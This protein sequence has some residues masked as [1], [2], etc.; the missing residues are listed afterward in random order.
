[1]NAHD[2]SADRRREYAADPW[3][4]VAPYTRC[5]VS[6]IDLRSQN[7]DELDLR[8]YLSI[9]RK[10][11]LLIF[12]AMIAVMAIVLCL[13]VLQTPQYR[14][15]ADVL[16]QARTSEQ[17]LQQ[18]QVR[19]DAARTIVDTEIEVMRSRSVVDAV[20]KDL[21]FRP[22]VS[23]ASRGETYVV[24]ITATGTDPKRA[25]DIANAY[26]ETYVRVR[27]EGQV[28]DLLAASEQVQE[29]LQGLDAETAALDDR[30]KTIDFAIAVAPNDR[31]A[32]SARIERDQIINSQQPDRLSIAT[33]RAGYVAQLDQLRLSSGLSKTGGARIVSE[34]VAASS[35]FKP[36]PRRSV[37]IALVLGLLVGVGLAFLREYLDDSISS[38]EDLEGAVP[39]LD[40]LTVVPV[41]GDWKDRKMAKL[42]SVASPQS[43]TAE[44]YR[45]LRTSMQFVGIDHTIKVTQITSPNPGEGKSTT[46]ANLGVQLSRTGRRVVLVDCDLRRPRLHEFFDLDNDIGFTS[47]LL[48]DATVADALAPVKGERNLVV[49]PSGPVPPNPSELLSAKRTQEV[50]Q[51]LGEQADFVLVDSPP[52]LPVS[53][54]LVLSRL[55]DATML[56]IAAGTTTKRGAHRAYELLEQIDAPVIG[57]VLNSVES[58]TRYDGGYGS[59]G[60]YGYVYGSPRKLKPR[61]PWRREHQPEPEPERETITIP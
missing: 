43:A 49:V 28:D 12:A 2:G 30:V 52:V 3:C 13:T 37:A 31:E 44:A 29:Q 19:S 56:V 33:R 58:G 39:A 42:V 27:R 54:S 53:D 23:I 4:A 7:A 41:V 20:E 47:I 16:L 24:S 14:S 6:R 45:T 21:G 8:D 61:L 15:G 57:A 40:L 17:I 25:A 36:A 55:V 60:S 59:Y 18:V 38:R 5:N 22:A 10:R 34:A 51:M 46:L 26:A 35:P 9:I 32:A 11:K 1:L 48:G 50:L